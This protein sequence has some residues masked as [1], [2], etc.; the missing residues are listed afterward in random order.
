[1]KKLI[2]VFL[3]AVL[4][5]AGCAAAPEEP[6]A[7]YTFTDDLGRTV[8]VTAW[9]RTAALMGSLADIWHLAGGQVCAAPDDAWEDFDLDLPA[10]VVDLGKLNKLSTD[11]LLA[12]DPDFVI[13]SSKMSGQVA[14]EEIL[15]SSGITVAYFDIG[16][17]ES[18]LRL[19]KICTDL[20]GQ[21]QRYEQYGTAQQEKI[22]ASLDRGRGQDAPT[23]LVLRASAASIRVKNSDG[24]MLGGMLR[25]FGCVNIADSDESLLETLSVES[26]ALQDP[27]KIFFIQTGSDMDAVRAAVEQMF[28]DDPLWQELTAVKN[29]EVY[30][31][32]KELYNLKPNARFAEAY[33]RL[34]KILYES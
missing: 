18:Y 17:F 14:L 15:E 3:A 31:M 2:A 27:E 33:E 32:E 26:V 4:A 34:E 19:L 11:L 28:Q 10:D 6:S 8:T 30:F 16:D 24:T 7:G 23:V 20:T 1:M 5:L 21:S 25:D 12:S 9:D 29:G 13:A 22:Q